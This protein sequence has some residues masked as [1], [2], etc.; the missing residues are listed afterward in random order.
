MALSL[1]LEIIIGLVVVGVLLGMGRDVPTI[2]VPGEGYQT[3]HGYHG[4][5]MFH[6]DNGRTYKYDK[7]TWR[8][9]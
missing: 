7:G 2:Y 3:G 5:D 9:D 4:G 6:G 8:P 1:I